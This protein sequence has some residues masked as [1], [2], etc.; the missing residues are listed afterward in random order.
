MV[1]R[2]SQCSA[3]LT[4]LLLSASSTLRPGTVPLLW[5]RVLVLRHDAGGLAS[6]TDGRLGRLCCT[7]IVGALP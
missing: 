2:S 6:L 1:M 4:G 3:R 7:R 5:G